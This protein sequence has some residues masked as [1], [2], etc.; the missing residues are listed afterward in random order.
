[1]G[2][3]CEPLERRGAAG[4]SSSLPSAAPCALPQRSEH[5]RPSVGSLR[6]SARAAGSPMGSVAVAARAG[7]WRPRR[8]CS[9]HAWPSLSMATV[10]VQQQQRAS[11]IV[12]V[13]GA[14]R[15]CQI[16]TRASTS[17][18]ICSPRLGLC[19]ERWSRSLT[20]LA[21]SQTR[22]PGAQIGPI[23][24]CN[25]CDMRAGGLSGAI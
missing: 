1:M 25:G 9:G 14:F 5:R 21:A 18:L 24:T 20:C 13:D 2:G 6:S 3:G 19:P 17:A 8:S 4:A 23:P 15:K 16:L 10:E 12:L 7:C 11:G 22:P